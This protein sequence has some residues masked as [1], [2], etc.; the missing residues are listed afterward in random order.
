[1][2]T[3]QLIIF[4]LSI[5]GSRYIQ[6][7]DAYDIMQR[8]TEVSYRQ[9]NSLKTQ[10][11]MIIR[12]KRGRERYRQMTVLRK[13]DGSSGVEQK[14]FVYFKKPAD[15][16][17]MVFMVWKNKNGNDD[18]WLY[19]PA[20]D[21]VKRIAASDGRASFA[22]SHFVYEDVSGRDL[23]KD[24]HTIIKEDDRHFIIKSIPKRGEVVDFK[25]K[26]SRIDKKTYLPIEVKY[27]ND[28]DA[29][30]RSY[31]VL[32]VADVEGYPTVLESQILNELDGSKTTLSFVAVRYNL[33]VPDNIFSERFLRRPPIKLLL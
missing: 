28:N 11:S 15:V 18:R 20:M 8:A 30:Y 24:E 29:L 1:M 27:F 23:E 17:K 2:K 7:Q 19:L 25:Y 31:A 6:G 12:D 33:E 10:A 32:K 4:S 9:G 21:L 5:L 3:I 22:G 26:V 14:Y 13:S 16:N